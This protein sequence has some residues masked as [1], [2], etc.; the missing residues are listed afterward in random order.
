LTTLAWD[1]AA[2]TYLVD[3]AQAEKDFPKGE[4]VDAVATDGTRAWA[5]TTGGAVFTF[6][7]SAWETTAQSGDELFAKGRRFARLA[8]DRARE[9]LVLWGG[10][11]GTRWSNDTLLFQ[12]GAWRKSRKPGTKLAA[13]KAD[14]FWMYDDT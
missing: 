1:G 13:R 10:M 7:G 11:N 2:W 12:S 14:N 3:P 9:R 8:Y 4:R 5:V 6:N